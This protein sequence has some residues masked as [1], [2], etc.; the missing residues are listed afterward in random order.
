[1]TLKHYLTFD[2]GHTIVID[3]GI[4]RWC[5]KNGYSISCLYEIKTGKRKNYKNIINFETL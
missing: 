5:K 2:D 1:L 3:D 4:R